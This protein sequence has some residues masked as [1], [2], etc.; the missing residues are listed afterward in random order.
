MIK[1]FEI[2]NGDFKDFVKLINLSVS[3]DDQLQVE[4]SPPMSLAGN[5]TS[6]IVTLAD[7]N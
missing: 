5:M 4:V 2:Q 1:N 6:I 7:L 3:G